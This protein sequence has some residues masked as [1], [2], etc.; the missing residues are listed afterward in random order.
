MP[1]LLDFIP[2]I[3]FFL[4][5]KLKGITL[6]TILLMFMSFLQVLWGR[7]QN[8]R[9]QNKSLYTFLLIAVFGG[10]SL[11]FQDIRFLQW[12]PTILYWLFAL[13]LLL[14]PQFPRFKQETLLESLMKKAITLTKP[15]W[16]ILNR[17]WVCF[18]LIMGS[19]NLGVMYACNLDAWVNFKLFGTLGLS[20]AFLLIQGLWLSKRMQASP[21]ASPKSANTPFP[22]TP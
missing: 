10:A 19:L 17:I 18:F 20:L 6:A 12:K 3:V 16:Q 5:Y 8:G 9:F 15:D 11:A 1:F 22:P 21:S 7:Y 14:A 2:I 13:A 4:A